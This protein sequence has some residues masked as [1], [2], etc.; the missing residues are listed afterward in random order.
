MHG[1]QRWSVLRLGGHVGPGLW[2]NPVYDVLRSGRLWLHPDSELQFLHTDDVARIA[3]DLVDDG[4]QGEVVNVCGKGT[5]RLQDVMD[6]ASTEVTVEPDAPRVR[7]EVA[8]EKLSGRLTIPDSRETVRR[9]I[10]RNLPGSEQ[11]DLGRQP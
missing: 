10:E 3:L 11:P 9:F 6:W 2:K 8:T 1:A 5:V 4:V 7:Y